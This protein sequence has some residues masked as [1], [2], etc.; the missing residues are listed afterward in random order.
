MLSQS[1]RDYSVT[2]QTEAEN[3]VIPAC[4]KSSKAKRRSKGNILWSTSPAS[5]HIYSFLSL[6]YPGEFKSGW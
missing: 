3:D 4:D 2:A 6:C 5:S 1:Q